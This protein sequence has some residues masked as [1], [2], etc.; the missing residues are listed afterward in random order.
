VA[1]FLANILTELLLLSNAYIVTDSSPV[2]RELCRFPPFI[3]HEVP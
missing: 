1:K 3:G 2:A